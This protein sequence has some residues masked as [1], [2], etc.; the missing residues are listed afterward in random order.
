MIGKPYRVL[1]VDDS[2]FMR[3][4]I[5]RI[6]E[7][8]ERLEVV[9]VA[10]NG[11]EAVAKVEALEPDVITL[12]INMPVMDGLTALSHIM[13]IRPT[14]CVMVSSLTQTGALA[15]L[16]AFELGA[17]DYVEKPSGTVSLDIE[18]IAD[19]L[20]SK[21]RTAARARLRRPSAIRQRRDAW[22]AT[23]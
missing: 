19:E 9:D 22:R 6:L 3:R 2:A 8:D 4:Y 17:I 18:E 5:T 10:R 21:V 13:T 11:A 20:I 16:E 12:D 15:T 14:P 23:R 7:S 1:V